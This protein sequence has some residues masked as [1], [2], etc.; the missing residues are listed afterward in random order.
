MHFI[1]DVLIFLFDLLKI[2]KGSVISQD[3]LGVDYLWRKKFCLSLG[4]NM[5]FFKSLRWIW[6]FSLME[7][8]LLTEIIIVIL[9]VII[10]WNS[11]TLASIFFINS[12]D[13][14]QFDVAFPW[15]LL[16]DTKC[17]RINSFDKPCFRVIHFLF[18]ACITNMWIRK[19]I[20][21]LISL[22]YTWV[23]SII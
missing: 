8:L 3:V 17:L 21:A 5:S 13:C 2:L 22:S 19:S 6:R 10:M 9:K 11:R 23:I 4:M 12:V 14:A 20:Q 1:N 16:L 7:E 18:H 15:V